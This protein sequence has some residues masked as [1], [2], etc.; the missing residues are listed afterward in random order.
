MEDPGQSKQTNVEA[1][2]GPWREAIEVAVET[3]K[4]VFPGGE[5]MTHLDHHKLVI[6]KELISILTLTHN[7]SL[8]SCSL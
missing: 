5:V 1:I 3:T 6:P 2:G 8:P 4:A 7:Q